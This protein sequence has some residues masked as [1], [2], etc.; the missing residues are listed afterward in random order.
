MRSTVV[1]GVVLGGLMCSVAF[2]QIGGITSGDPRVKRLLDGLGFRYKVTK[3]HD[4]ELFFDVG[5]GRSH[6]VFINSDTE[7]YKD[8][9]IREIYA[10]SYHSKTRL[11]PDQ[12]RMLLKD[13]GDKKLGGWSLISN[14]EGDLAVFTVKAAAELNEDDMRSLIQL[15]TDAADDMEKELTGTDD[16]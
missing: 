9:E 5:D 8:F 11:P 13:S 12:L 7:K 1:L 3:S 15:V 2:G 4:F 16:L 6:R 10:A 14:E